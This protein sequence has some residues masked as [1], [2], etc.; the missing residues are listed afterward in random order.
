MRKERDDEEN[1]VTAI[2]QGQWLDMPPPQGQRIQFDVLI[3]FPWDP[4]QH[5]FSGE[6]DLLLQHRLTI[7]KQENS[8]YYPSILSSLFFAPSHSE[9]IME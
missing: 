9:S 1:P 7:D 3:L 2:Y 5:L 6:R 4:K 8:I